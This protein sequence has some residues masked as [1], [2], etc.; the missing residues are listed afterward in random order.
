MS[1]AIKFDSHPHH[2]YF[3]ELLRNRG[4]EEAMTELYRHEYHIALKNSKSHMN[5]YASYAEDAV[6]EALA[7]VNLRMRKWQQGKEAR[8]PNFQQMLHMNTKHRGTSIIRKL[9]DE[10][11]FNSFTLKNHKD[12]CGESLSKDIMEDLLAINSGS[13]RKNVPP[14]NTAIINDFMD[15]IR[16]LLPE[17]LYE[18]LL[19]KIHGQRGETYSDYCR[20]YSCSDASAR[21]RANRA[22]R[23]LRE[24]I[25]KEE[26][27]DL[28]CYYK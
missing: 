6:D 26:L 24:N 28:L 2:T 18:A 23:I 7:Y 14:E 17:E 19:C 21:E 4:V 12:N 1:S 10:V 16:H 11:L 20:V 8:M 25:D 5:R 22:I 15:R 27:R 13:N 3:E 9:K